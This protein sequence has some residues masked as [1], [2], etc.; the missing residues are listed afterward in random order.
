[1]VQA[2]S[3]ESVCAQQPAR[4]SLLQVIQWHSDRL[5][6]NTWASHKQLPSGLLQGLRWTIRRSQQVIPDSHIP[7]WAPE[8][9]LSG[10]HILISSL[11]AWLTPQGASR[12]ESRE[13]RMARG[14]PSM[15]HICLPRVFQVPMVVL[16]KTQIYLPICVNSH[17]AWRPLS[18][19]R[20]QVCARSFSIGI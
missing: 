18:I 11:I 17:Q 15:Y 6:F 9:N 10:L 3:R 13:H 2:R 4:R 20:P 5:Q 1:M 8:H 14:T 7:S 16:H 12:L 19:S